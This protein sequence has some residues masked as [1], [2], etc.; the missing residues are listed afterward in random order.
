MYLWNGR[1]HA[2]DT[3]RSIEPNFGHGGMKRLVEEAAARHADAIHYSA[4]AWIRL[5]GSKDRE[6]KD[7]EFRPS[8]LESLSRVWLRREET[9]R[10]EQRLRE[11]TSWDDPIVEKTGFVEVACQNYEVLVEDKRAGKTG[12]SGPS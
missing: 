1:V 5:G 11:I 12:G 6:A 3:L 4:S 2:S 9:D 10:A 8:V 7:L